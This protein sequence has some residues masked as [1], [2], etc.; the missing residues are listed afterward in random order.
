MVTT[1]FLLV[2]IAVFKIRKYKW[3]VKA[4]VYDQS[5]VVQ[6]S[7]TS[8]ALLI[9]LGSVLTLLKLDISDALRRCSGICVVSR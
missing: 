6:N 5:N 7:F 3:L 8:E 9:V 2:I 1:Q 4:N